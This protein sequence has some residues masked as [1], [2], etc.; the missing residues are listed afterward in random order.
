MLGGLRALF[1]MSLLFSD[2]AE[3]C[4]AVREAFYFVAVPLWGREG[5]RWRF[6][7][8][9]SGG[10]GTPRQAQ[11]VVCCIYV[12]LTTF[13]IVFMLFSFLLL[14]QNPEMAGQK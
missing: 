2:K 8:F 14:Y 5:R 3:D 13:V 6:Y 9:G 10:A 12:S 11:V 4:G 7:F 1:F